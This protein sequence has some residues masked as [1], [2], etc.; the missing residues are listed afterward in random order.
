MKDSVLEFYA[1]N[2]KLILD[3]S[4]F[5]NIYLVTN[6]KPVSQFLSRVSNLSLVDFTN[7]FDWILLKTL[8]RRPFVYMVYFPHNHI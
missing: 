1:T 8:G 6:Q 3:T 7:L 4:S 5:S 2:L